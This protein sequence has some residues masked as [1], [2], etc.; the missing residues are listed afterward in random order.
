MKRIIIS[1]ML[2]LGMSALLRAQ[3]TE[4]GSIPVAFSG[5]KPGITD[6]VSAI[7]SPEDI[8][9]SLG[10]MKD[11]WDLYRAGKPLP[12]GRS[13]LV[14]QKNG[15]LRYDATDKEDDGT[16]FSTCIEF[17]YWNCSDGRHRLVG[18]NTVCS[19]NGKPFMGQFSGLSYLM[20]DGKTRRLSPIYEGDLGID[21]D[22]PEGADLI[23]H[24]LPR[25][26]K[27]VEYRFSTPSGEILAKYT[28]AGN[29]FVK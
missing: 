13:F 20:Y 28:W 24:K 25:T 3:D 10:E 4:D 23:V 2:L 29:K 11:N 17:C 8:G 14:D 1:A 7:L 9:E 22:Y 27:T 15:Y 19:R 18:E 21:I 6:F 26:G 16:V 12:Q 5:Q